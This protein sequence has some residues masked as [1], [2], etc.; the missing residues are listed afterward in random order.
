MRSLAIHHLNVLSKQETHQAPNV[1]FSIDQ[2]HQVMQF[3]IACRA[4]RCP[5]KAAALHALVEA[6]RVVPS[7]TQPR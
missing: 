2:A 5:R 3:H 4:S 6:G 1:R 7:A